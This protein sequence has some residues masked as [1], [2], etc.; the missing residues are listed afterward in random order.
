MCRITWM[1]WRWLSG[2]RRHNVGWWNVS[3]RCMLHL[4]NHK[5]KLNLKGWAENGGVPKA[6]MK[7]LV[8]QNE[9]N[10][11]HENTRGRNETNGRN[12]FLQSLHPSIVCMMFT[13]NLFVAKHQWKCT[14]TSRIPRT[15]RWHLSLWCWMRHSW[16][17]H[18]FS[19]V[20]VVWSAWIANGFRATAL[21]TAGDFDGFVID[22][23][24]YGSLELHLDLV[25]IYSTT[26]CVPG[27]L[28]LSG[29]M[30]GSR[31]CQGCEAVPNPTL[32]DP[33]PLKAWV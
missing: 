24:K 1:N 18:A 29:T 17:E 16:V 15:F 27:L 3:R 31:C 2:M 28:N 10:N 12:K 20:S 9:F 25:K 21:N 5:G 33:L 6:G 13:G 11:C 30:R 4:S 8:F 22:L 26:C 14:W 23:F 32:G 7:E 19:K